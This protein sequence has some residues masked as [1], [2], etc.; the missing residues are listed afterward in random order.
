MGVKRR[1]VNTYLVLKSKGIN[2]L[3]LNVDR[4]WVNGL[5]ATMCEPRWNG[6]LNTMWRNSPRR[7]AL[8]GETIPWCDGYSPADWRARN[9]E[10]APC[11]SAK[12]ERAL[13]AHGQA[14]APKV[15]LQDSTYY[16]RWL[17]FYCYK[18]QR[19]PSFVGAFPNAL[20]LAGVAVCFFCVHTQFLHDSI[21]AAKIVTTKRK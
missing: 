2:Y 8:G 20:A 5:A 16:V 15:P 18:V 19:C 1:G 12:D 4:P 10:L 21:M 17:D 14:I 6:T 7:R 13:D 11:W 9:R 3:P